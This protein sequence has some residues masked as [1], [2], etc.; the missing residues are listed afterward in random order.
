MSYAPGA[1]VAKRVLAGPVR[2][3]EPLTDAR[4]LTPATLPPGQLAYPLRLEDPDLASLLRVGDRI[5]LY[6]ATSTNTPTAEPLARAVPVI[7]LPTPRGSAG[8]S[9]GALIVIS[10]ARDTIARIA[11]ATANTRITVAITRDTS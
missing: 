6:A 5:D 3:G 10:A 9:S 1:D 8:S 7:A 11:Q 4:F 2:S